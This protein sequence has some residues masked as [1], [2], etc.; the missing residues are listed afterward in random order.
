MSDR[1]VI[2]IT[3]RPGRPFGSKDRFPR[4]TRLN[5]EERAKRRKA[6]AL[7]YDHSHRENAKQY[8]E[9]NRERL[10]EWR[11]LYMKNYRKTLT[12]RISHSL[13]N[14]MYALMSGEKSE[15]AEGLIGCNL[16]QLKIYLESLFKPGMSWG[17]YG[18]WHIDHIRPCASFD[19]R[20][21]EEQKICFHYSNLQPLWAH[22]N[23]VKWAKVSNE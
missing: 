3:R 14:R 18:E 2:R 23:Q 10:R 12:Y 11:R 17:N 6:S 4:S 9:H 7:K 8:V 22:E 21:P 1:L 20:S 19:L 5:P 16:K 15:K 13:R